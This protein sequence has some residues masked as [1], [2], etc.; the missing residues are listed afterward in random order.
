MSKRRQT[1]LNAARKK[2]GMSQRPKGD[3]IK[4]VCEQLQVPMPAS[5]D[6]RYK[7]MRDWAQG[8]PT[9]K[10]I[11]AA[12]VAQPSIPTSP[13]VVKG[14]SRRKRRQ[15]DRAKG[16][17][18]LASYEWRRLRMEVIKDRGARCECCGST[19]QKD[20]IVINVDHIKPRRLFPELALEK[21]NLQVLC[22]VCNHGKGNWDHTDWRE[23][24]NGT[25]Q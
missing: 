11:K 12:R 15:A 2:A 3:V 24:A 16:D 25:I 20:G 23:K 13:V 1:I 19:P 7:L 14:E 22:D 21:T 5:W 17:E 18:F 4:Y 6:A 8:Q 10:A 9:S